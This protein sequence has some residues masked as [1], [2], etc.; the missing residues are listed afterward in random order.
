MCICVFYVSLRISFVDW[1][2]KRFMNICVR[3]IEVCVCLWLCPEV[4]VHG[5]QDVKIHLLANE[6]TVNRTSSWRRTTMPSMPPWSSWSRTARTPCCNNCLPETARALASSTSS[7]WGP[8]SAGS[9]MSSWRNSGPL[10]V[11]FTLSV[12]P[13]WS[14]FVV[15]TMIQGY[16]FASDIYV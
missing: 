1:F 9:W 13:Q 12:W 11:A 15:L 10:W 7:A 4:T 3:G 6:L 2:E 5:W 8:S 14:L 16:L